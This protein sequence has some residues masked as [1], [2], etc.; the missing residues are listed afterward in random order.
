VGKVADKNVEKSAD[1]AC[2]VCKES[3]SP[4]LAAHNMCPR[5]WRKS[6]KEQKDQTKQKKVKPDVK[7]NTATCNASSSISLPSYLLTPEV[8]QLIALQIANRQY[9]SLQMDDDTS[10]TSVFQGVASAHVSSTLPVVSFPASVVSQLTVA[11][12]AA[13]LHC[14]ATFSDLVNPRK[15]QTPISCG[16]IGAA[17]AFTHVGLDVRMP[18]GARDLYWGPGVQANLC[19]LG[20]MSRRNLGAFMMDVD[21]ILYFYYAGKLLFSAP[22]QE[23]HLYPFDSMSICDHPLVNATCMSSDTEYWSLNMP[24]H[25]VLKTGFPIEQLD[26]MRIMYG[27]VN[28]NLNYSA[29]PLQSVTAY[30]SLSNVKFNHE[31]MERIEM[32]GALLKYLHYPSTTAVATTISMGAFSMASPLDAKDIHNYDQLYGP[33]PHYLAGKYS[34]KPMPSSLNP[35]AP[36][37]GY[38]LNMDIRKLKSKSPQGFTHAIHVVS[39]HEGYFSVIPAKTASGTDLFDALY[40][41][42]ATTYNAKGHK[43]VVAHADAESV[44]KS[45]RA[46]FGSIGITLTLSPPGQHAQR[47]ERYIQTMDNRVRSTIDSLHYVLPAEFELYL[48]MDVAHK[49]NSVANTKSF[50]LSPYEK[51]HKHRKRFHATIPFLPF[52]SVCM[53]N[54]GEAKRTKNAKDLGYP[55]H[56]VVKQE[57]G[58]CMGEDPAFPQSYIFYVQ[59][60]GQIVPRRVIKV[61]PNNIIPFN[62]QLKPSMF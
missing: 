34:Q 19:S 15:L 51:V 27:K 35:P 62:W 21:R 53:V 32:A 2:M 1:K 26:R 55:V 54:M 14:T 58:V 48:E 29:K 61:L 8:K 10:L 5:C 12:C 56:N 6:M 28:N 36:S 20:Y 31:Q 46:N 41:Y 44:M 57:I 42:I 37:V 17:T 50:P 43:V 16:G 22:M 13:T 60:S 11:D 23:N 47:C 4:M 9:D 30:P 40:S 59:S 52:G 45:M 25:V 24:T 7:G 38:A 3:F 39:E 33:N 18:L 49:M